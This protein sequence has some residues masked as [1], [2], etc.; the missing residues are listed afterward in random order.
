MTLSSYQVSYEISPIVLVGG[1]AGTGMLPLISILSSKNFDL[2]I[3]SA[4]NTIGTDDYFGHFRI[5]PGHTLMDNEVATYP[6]ANQTV[7]ANAII[8]D[9]LRLS[10]EMLVPATDKVTV[11]SKLSIMTSLKST[12]DKHTAQGGWYNV[13]TPS[14]I[15]QGCLLT[16]LVDGTDIEDGS[17]A[18]TR[19]VWSFIQPLLTASAAAAAQNQAMNKISQATRNSGNPPGSAPLSSNLGQPSSNIVQ[20]VVPAASGSLASNVAP[21]STN[22]NSV[23]V[24]SV[25]PIAP[26]S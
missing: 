26:G 20:N 16:S 14:Y 25:S 7:A 15:Y 11:E 10:I 4:A 17:Q 8:T 6:V 19:W 23:S 13:A 18:Q 21:V 24:Q 9:P 1:V 2:G 3:L 5:L 12:L 22:N